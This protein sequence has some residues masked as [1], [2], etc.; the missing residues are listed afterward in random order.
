[1]KGYINNM[2]ILITGGTG[3]LGSHLTKRLINEVDSITILTTNVRQNTSLKS[4]GV[5]NHKKINLVKGD[6][7][8]FDFL[9]LLF[10]E[11][12]FDGIFHLAALSEVRKCQ[13]DAKLA[14]DI[15]VGGTIN[16]LEVARL[17]GNVKFV[18]VSSSDKAYG[19]GKLPYLEDYLLNGTA[20]YEVSKS[21]TDLIARSYY[22][23]YGLPTVV[24]RCSNLY[25]G[26]DMNFSRV[27]PNNIRKI[28]SGECPMVWR[29]S[30]ESVREFLY[31]DDAVDAYL[32]LID[33]IEITKGNAYNIGSG[34]KITIQR[35][36]Q[37][38]LNI[39]DSNLNIEYKSK[40]FP[41][42]SNQY[43]DSTKIKNDTGWKSKINLET[44]LTKTIDFYKKYYDKS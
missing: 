33:N 29:G 1:M 40:S 42:I 7:R 43:L 20:T 22:N 2:N 16:V 3:F 8:D 23:N 41:E 30:E 28:L 35:L 37:L 4:L 38:L 11:Y 27:I 5:D 14:F 17:Y 21:A 19:K 13:S 15:N 39:M 36:L 32:T 25:G 10:V 31:V 6:V 34:E 12:E 44:G 9:R 18:I 24:T 26:G